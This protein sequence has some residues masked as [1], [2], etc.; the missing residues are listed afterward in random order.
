MVM[1]NLMSRNKKIALAVLSA[2]II[3]FIGC[4]A[5]FSNHF[6]L[7]TRIDGV[8]VSGMTPEEADKKLEAFAA[9]YTLQ[10]NERGDVKEK[11]TGSD[12]GLKSGA[13]GGSAALKKEQNKTLFIMAL[14]KQDALKLGAG[15]TV[16]E[17]KLQEAYSKLGCVDSSKV[18][19]PKNA[20]IVY[21]ANG[22]EVVKEVYGN[23]ANRDVLYPALKNAAENGV[24]ELDLEKIKAYTDPVY[25]SNSDKV[26]ET[27][28]KLN[29]YITAQITYSHDG[30]TTVVGREQIVDWAEVDSDLNV[31]FN[32]TEMANFVSNLASYYNTVGT[33]RTFT[34]STGSV[35]RISGG[36]YGWKVSTS[37]ETAYLIDAIE[38]G[39]VTDRTPAYALRGEAAA[40]NDIGSTYVEISVTAQHLW[41]YK[42]GAL[43]AQG[44]VVTGNVSQGN[45]TPGGI[46]MLKYKERNATLKGENY[47]VPVSYW[48]P[49]NN[50]IGIHDA[51]W[52][53]EFG[54]QIYQTSGS[55]GCV[56]APPELA[57]IIFENITP[58]VPVIVYY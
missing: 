31:V 2:A 55:H 50:N 57:R 30:G 4:C 58:G 22:Y 16:D 41:Y 33:A 54:G 34:T 46:Y 27:L 25:T 52:R 20:S 14:F 15:F 8:N 23:K 39:K 48:M 1:Q 47:R 43:I 26:K 44:D 36:D 51:Y 42:D 11:I 38:N 35:I 19:E 9:S 49:F 37:K 13:E 17:S 28:N 24:T 3:L 18:T 7:G 6:Y 56:N 40:P 53:T 5:F 45:G 29:K 32:E 10:L 21:G 12:I